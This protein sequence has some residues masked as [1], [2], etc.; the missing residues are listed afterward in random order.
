M[1]IAPER[2]ATAAR[3]GTFALCGE[4]AFALAGVAL[5]FARDDLDW[6]AAPLSFY[7][8]GAHGAVLKAAYV[9]LG[10]A[11]GALGFGFRAIAAPAQ[12]KMAPALFALAGVALVLTA[13]A[14]SATRPGPMSL[15]AR[16]HGFAAMTAFL[17]VTLAMLW[18]SLRLRGDADWRKR[19][20][21]ALPLAV[22]AF[23]ALLAHALLR[24]GPRG[25]SQKTVIILIVCWLAIAAWRLRAA[26]MR[27]A[28]VNAA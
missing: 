1:Q 27:Q 11:L 28:P 24:I 22:L 10:A 5:Q 21:T 25:V 9:G 13:F 20:P 12:A 15:E 16:I 3:L 7:L 23:L 4:L 14:E 19:F 18:Q 6:T 26:A 2:Y 17:S 8:V